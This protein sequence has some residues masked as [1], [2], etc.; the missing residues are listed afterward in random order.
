MAGKYLVR[1]IFGDREIG[2]QSVCFDG[3][4]PLALRHTSPLAFIGI[5]RDRK[6]S[7]QALS[8]LRLVMRTRRLARSSEP[9]NWQSRAGRKAI[10]SPPVSNMLRSFVGLKASGG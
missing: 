4:A 6:N 2:Y 10:S 5:P 9:W 1:L 3:N 7:S 8:M